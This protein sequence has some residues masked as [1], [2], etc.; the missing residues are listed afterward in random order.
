MKTKNEK[1]S[2]ASVPENPT[3]YR[4]FDD[5][6]A[7]RQSWLDKSLGLDRET[8]RSQKRAIAAELFLQTRLLPRIEASQPIDERILVEQLV[9]FRRSYQEGD[10]YFEMAQVAVR[11]LSRFQCHLLDDEHVS[12]SARS[13]AVQRELELFTI[14]GA[15]DFQAIDTAVRERLYSV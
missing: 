12:L 10:V 11:L 2:R 13:L 3:L 15:L 6:P 14:L 9:D 4:H 7:A 8:P 5:D 1:S